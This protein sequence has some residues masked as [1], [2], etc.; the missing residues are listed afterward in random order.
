MN[1]LPAGMLLRRRDVMSFF[2]I[3]KHILRKWR[4][5]KILVPRRVTKDG[6]FWYMRHECLA[7]KETLEKQ[8]I[9]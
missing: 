9:K 1:E 4:K 6:N 3:N 5:S 2:G 7:L 8:E